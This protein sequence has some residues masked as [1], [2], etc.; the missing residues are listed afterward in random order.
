MGK[1]AAHTI[2][3]LKVGLNTVDN[4]PAFFERAR[5]DNCAHLEFKEIAIGIDRVSSE[6]GYDAG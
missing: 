4:G 5:R 3:G 2:W 1:S 6:I